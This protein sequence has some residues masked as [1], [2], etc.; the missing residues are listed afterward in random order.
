[1]KI[2]FFVGW[3]S[4]LCL[5]GMWM[6]LTAQESNNEVERLRK[7]LQEATE[8]LDKVTKENREVIEDLR[9]RLEELEASKVRQGTAPA[10]DTSPEQPSATSTTSEDAKTA[11]SAVEKPSWKPSDPIRIG[12][13][14]AFLDLGMVATFAAGASTTEHIEGE[15]NLGGHDPNQRGFTVQ[16]VETSFKGVVD[17]YFQAFSTINFRIDSEGETS[18]EL[19][20]AYMQSLSLPGNLQLKAGQYFTEFGRHNTL[21]VHQFNSVDT[22]LINGR[23][24]GPDGVR[25]P[26]ARLSWLTPTPFYSELFFSVQDSHGETAA[27]FRG[28][29]GHHGD[30]GDEAPFAYREAEND[31]GVRALDDLLYGPRYVTSFDLTD[32]QVVLLGGS[33]LFGPNNSGADGAGSTDTQIYGVDLTWK[34]KS[35]SHRGGFPFVLWQTE[36][37]W[38]KYDAGSFDWDED[39]NAAVDPG[40][41]ADPLTGLPA[42]MAGEQ[43]DDYGFYTQLLYGFH[44]GWVAGLRWDYVTS[45]EADYE[46]RGLTLDGEALGRDPNRA[47]R[48][49]LSPNLTWYPT[50]FTKFRLQYNYDNRKGIGEDH[51]VWLQFEFVLG[52]HA[53]HTF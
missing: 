33:A 32:E 30:D 16:G 18:T 20:E 42:V 26:G 14:S 28:E 24:L 13:S 38:R 5:S 25:N 19:E 9:K 53:A 8:T 37:I 17:P 15:L 27:P 7:Q 49:R 46:S 3:T 45:D 35:K 51:S 41:I 44:K 22:P 6:P 1:M 48:W 12:N 21:H 50:E 23:L 11:S 29:E 10:T 43:L 39:G 2:K 36:G 34:W 31:R 4:A 47:T 52:A 40:E